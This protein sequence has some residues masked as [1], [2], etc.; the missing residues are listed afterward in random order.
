VLL[1]A[2]EYTPEA[3]VVVVAVAVAVAVAKG[4]TPLIMPWQ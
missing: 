2:L 4:Y 3:P 1:L